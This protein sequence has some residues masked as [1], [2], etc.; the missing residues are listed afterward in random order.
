M[1]EV[2]SVTQSKVQ[3]SKSNN[4]YFFGPNAAALS[5]QDYSWEE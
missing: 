1:L 5:R 2:T 3:A 4:F